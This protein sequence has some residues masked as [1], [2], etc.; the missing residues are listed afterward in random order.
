MEEGS[1]GLG[2]KILVARRQRE[3]THNSKGCHL[4]FIRNKYNFQNIQKWKKGT[5]KIFAK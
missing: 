2:L 1:G 4:I 5:I 3:P